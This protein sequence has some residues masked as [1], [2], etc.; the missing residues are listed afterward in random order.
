MNLVEVFRWHPHQPL[1]AANRQ[2]VEITKDKPVADIKVGVSI[3]RL[4]I[5]EVAEIAAILRPQIGIRRDIQRVR[6]GVR[7]EER[8][9]M[10]EAFSARACSES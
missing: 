4:G 9:S 7:G 5:L 8:Q 1:T 3:F 10:R 6:P 2:L